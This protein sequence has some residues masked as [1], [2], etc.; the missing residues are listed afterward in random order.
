[1]LGQDIHREVDIVF[2]V[3]NLNDT[4]QS[5][6]MLMDVGDRSWCHNERTSMK[7]GKSKRIKDKIVGTGNFT[8]K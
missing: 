2:R 6:I 5:R 4:T 3:L 8:N 1:M 7:T